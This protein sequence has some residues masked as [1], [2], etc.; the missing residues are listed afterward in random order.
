MINT[1]KGSQG[2][3]VL[4]L[5]FAMQGSAA[6]LPLAATQSAGKGNAPAAQVSQ[7]AEEKSALDK[8]FRSAENNPQILL[9]HL[10]AF[11][12]RFPRSP[13]R[14][15]VLR[16]ICTYALQANDPGAVVKYGT[17]LLEATPD[18]PALLSLLV[19]ALVR[20]NDQVSRV[21]AIDYTSRLIENAERYRATAAG[22]DRNTAEQRAEHIASL[23]AQRAALHRDSSDPDKALADD[24]KSFAI[25]PTARIAERLGDAALKKGDSR[26][27]LD[28]YLT[29]FV[30]PDR[31]PDPARRQEIRRKLGSLYVAQHHSEEGLGDLVLARDDALMPQIAARFSSQP[32]N[33][34][35]HDPFEFVLE[36][37]DGAA[38]PLA[39]YR[40]KVLVVDFWATWCGPCHLQGKLLDEVA[41][42]YRTDSSAAFLAL[43]VDQDRGGVPAFLEHEGWSIP[44][45]YAQGLDQLLNVRELPTILIFDRQGRI[46]FRL[47]GVDPGSFEQE[48]DKHLRQTLQASEGRQR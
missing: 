45:A 14:E 30:F 17:L 35:R 25:Y 44:A 39:G 11:L 9:E 12:D 19:N 20:Q 3:L 1:A 47:E 4:F 43:N 7:D 26:R 16:T 18:D 32:Q 27:A 46:V 10:E 2:V 21:H 37:M 24:E 6:R 38:L 31:S 34:G 15:L 48:L 23:Y 28:F 41:K 40:G 33:E 22:F 29:A 8:A 42:N 36:R 13:R 5:Y